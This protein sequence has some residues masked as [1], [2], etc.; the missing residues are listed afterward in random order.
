MKIDGRLTVALL[1]LACGLS[2]HAQAD[3]R[4]AVATATIDQFCGSE[5]GMAYLPDAPA[6]EGQP[7]MHGWAKDQRIVV[8][9]GDEGVD[10]VIHPRTPFSDKREAVMN[11]TRFFEVGWTDCPPDARTNNI[12]STTVKGLAIGKNE[13][14]EADFIYR[15]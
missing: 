10:V 7:D 11:L 2:Q 15:P 12:L 5:G 6:W 3:E 4:T 13:N 14:G 9:S 1:C 8:T